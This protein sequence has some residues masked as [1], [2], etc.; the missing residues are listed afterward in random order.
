MH[1]ASLSFTALNLTAGGLVNQLLCHVGASPMALR[2]KAEMAVLDDTLSRDSYN[3]AFWQQQCT[4]S[5]WGHS[6][7]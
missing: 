4:G 1:M 2:L 6:L 5:P 7:M 3:S